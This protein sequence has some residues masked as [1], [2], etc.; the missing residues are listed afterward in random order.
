MGELKGYTYI[1]Y[2]GFVS[3]SRA[4]SFFNDM[5][6]QLQLFTQLSQLEVFISDI[7]MLVLSGKKENIYQNPGNTKEIKMF[8]FLY[9]FC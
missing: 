7:S 5:N 2:H 1:P 3:N 4:K 9:F 6:T 8:Y